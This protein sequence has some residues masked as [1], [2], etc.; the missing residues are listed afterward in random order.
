MTASLVDRTPAGPNTLMIPTCTLECEQEKLLTS[1]QELTLT[2][3]AFAQT[4]SPATRARFARMLMLDDAFDELAALLEPVPTESL[5]FAERLLLAN[6]HL[7]REQAADDALA[8]A[9]ATAAV[10]AAAGDAERAEALALVAKAEARLGDPASAR[11]TLLKALALDPYNKN[12]CKRLAAIDLTQGRPDSVLAATR[13]LLDQGVNHARLLAARALAQALADDTEAARAT[14]GF[15]WL[16]QAEELA[17][18]P[19]WSDIHAFNAALAGE[20]LAHPGMRYDRYGSASHDTFRIEN[21][22]RRDTPLFKLLMAQILQA[23][24]RHVDRAATSDHPWAAARPARG[25]LRNWCVITHGTGFEDWHVHQFGWLSGVYYVRIPTSIS[26]GEER[27]GCLA[28]GLP[29]NLAG[30]EASAKY[31]ERIVR[32]REG[33]L[34]TFPSH[35]YHRTYPHGSGEE[36]ICVAFDLRPA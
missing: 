22:A 36:R 21:P 34:L 28:F 13:Q 35:T 12:A 6:A 3:S 15:D 27:G 17:P 25:Y 23:T 19:G 18:P 5:S 26:Q 33:L 32:P 24:G 8:R 29:A 7:S 2:R 9:V 11:E 31:G 10:A 14:I 30:E 20:L 4:G 16:H 1:A